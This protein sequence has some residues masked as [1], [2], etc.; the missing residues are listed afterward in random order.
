MP[1]LPISNPFEPAQL[2]G[3][4]AFALGVACFAETDDRRFKIFMALECLSYALHFSL[5]GQPTA[6][7]SSLVSLGR[8][9][10]AIR[11]RSPWVAGFFIALSLSLGARLQTGWLSLLPIAA[12]CIGTTALFFLKGMQMRLLMLVGTLLWLAN[13]L[14]VGSIG[15]SLLEAT[16]AATNIMTLLRLRRRTA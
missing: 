6:V 13:N 8:S 12:S 1:Q 10:A 11:S 5:L 9:V 4:A 14:W 7:A 3:Y 16:I 15:G 2:F